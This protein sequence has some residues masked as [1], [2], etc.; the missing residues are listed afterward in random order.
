M[1][2]FLVIFLCIFP[3][4]FSLAGPLTKENAKAYREEG[5]RA[6]SIGDLMG[7]LSWYQKA[8]QLDPKLAQAY[9][10]M[11]VIYEILGED[12]K[13]LEPYLKALEIDPGYLPAYTNLAFLYEKRGDIDSAVHYWQKRYELGREGDYWWEVSCQ[14]LLKLGAYPAVRKRVLER[15]AAILS[16]DVIR[17]NKE[18]NLKSIKDAKRHFRIGNKAFKEK[19]YKTAVKE[20]GTVFLINPSDDQLLSRTLSRYKQAR[21]LFLRQQTSTSAKNALDYID[22]EDYSSAQNKLGEALEAISHITQEK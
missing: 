20:F 3:L 4:L 14:H 8:V 1:R 17:K 12:D 5:Q 11:G 15:K 22:Q 18:E 13:A 19:D 10:D 7:A 9:N 6:Q 21:R 16:S 2:I